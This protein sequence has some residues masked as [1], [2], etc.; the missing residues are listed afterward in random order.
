M[1]FATFTMVYLE[2][3]GYICAYKEIVCFLLAGIVIAWVLYGGVRELTA[4]GSLFEP[5]T[6]GVVA[7]DNAPELIFIFDFFNEYVIDLEFLNITEA[8][9][10]LEEG[11]IPAFVEL[12]SD[13][14]RDIF[15]GINSPFMVHVN[16][17]FPL[18]GNLVQL[19][20]S[21]GIAY[22]SVS[23]AGVFATFEYALERGMAWDDIQRTLLIPV[24]M[25][26][27]QELFKYDDM[28]V[29]EVVLLAEGGGTYFIGRFA[30]FWHM[31]GLMALVRFL[32][33]YS[34]GIMARFKLA[35]VPLWK[36]Y[37]IKWLGLFFVLALMSGFIAP[38]V[39]VAGALIASVYT[40]TFGT[41]AGK[42]LTGVRA[43]GMFI[44]F[45][46]LTKYFASGGIVPFVFLPQG[47]HI[48]RF[49]SINYWVAVL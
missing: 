27:V 35:G 2:I 17:R 15:Y 7:H 16:E 43:R 20:A 4:R 45:A 8:K 12:P 26:F 42:L 25:A 14:T 6:V 21:G 37:S 46:A 34:K 41:L 40:A 33:G 13:F 38:V 49:L 9:R 23:Q 18:Q 32:G 29:R 3:K 24:N 44:F 31:L 48:M 5:F 39:G 11:E 36:M 28:F 10:R 22:L 19:L 1:I 30:V 47:L